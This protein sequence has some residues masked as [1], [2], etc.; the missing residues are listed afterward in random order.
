[1]GYLD[2]KYIVVARHRGNLSHDHNAKLFVIF[3][4]EQSAK[5]LIPEFHP[6]RKLWKTVLLCGFIKF[7][8]FY[9]EFG[10]KFTKFIK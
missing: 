10:T 2:N 7:I 6:R 5:Q 1:M 8:H 9:Y 4:L 3:N